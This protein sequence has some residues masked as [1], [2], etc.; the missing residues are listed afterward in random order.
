MK[1]KNELI[2]IVLLLLICFL[3]YASCESNIS[4]TGDSE[5]E[6][7][8]IKRFFE[9]PPTE[10]YSGPLWVWN[11]KITREKI[12]FQLQ[13]FKEENVDQVF[14]HPRPGLITE[15][16]SSE[17]FELC[18]YT[19]DKAKELDMNVWLYD[20]NSFPS[21]FAG[22]H[23]QA[24]MP[25]SYQQGS[26]LNMIKLSQLQQDSLPKE[27]KAIIKQEN[28]QWIDVTDHLTQELGKKG[29]YYVFELIHEPTSGWYGGFAYVDLLYPG[30]TEKF[31]QVTMQGYEE[32]IGD[33]F[34]KRVPGIFTDE[35]NISPRGT[36]EGIKW[37]PHLF[38]EF[39][40]RWGYDLK[41]HLPSLFI[42][43]GDWKKIRHNYYGLLLEL[44]IERWSKPWHEY[45]EANNLK[46]TGH[47]WEH[48][49]PSPHHGGD[50]MAMYAWHQIPA[51]D[52]LF[53]TN[54]LRPDQ[55]GN[56]RA[57]KELSSVV[58]QLG[59]ERALS[60]TYGGAG[61]EL[62]FEDM[63]RLGDW[64]YALGVNFLNQHLAYMTLKGRRKG[65]FPQSISYHAPYWEDYGVL[66]EYY[67]RLSYVLSQGKQLNNTLVIEPTTAAWMYYSPVKPSNRLEEIKNEF[68]D[69]LHLMEKYQLEYD[70]ASEN[71][72]KDHGNVDQNEFVVGLRNYDLVIFPPGLDNLDKTTV[73]L[74]Q[75]YI[76]NGGKI[77]SLVDPPMYVDGQTSD[78]L[79]QLISGKA[80][81]WLQIEQLE[82]ALEILNEP[83][84]QVIDPADIE[85]KVYHQRRKLKDGQIL[86]WTNF[87]KEKHV[88]GAFKIKG[89]AISEMDPFTGQI[90]AYPFQ[91]EDQLLSAQFELA[92]AQS[93]LLFIH[94]D[95]SQNSATTHIQITNI[96]VLDT[97]PSTIKRNQPNTLTLDYLDLKIDGA[98]YNDLYFSMA[99]D[100]VYK[101]HGLAQY[102]RAGYDPWAVAV[103]YRTNILD[104]GKDWGE[105]TGYEATYHFTV[106]ENFTPESLSAVVEW[107]HLYQVSINGKAVNP[108]PEEWWLDQSFA[109]FDIAEHVKP[110]VNHL[111][112][113][114]QPMDIHAEVEPV[115]LRGDFGVVSATSG[116]NLI[117]PTEL[118]LGSW[119]DQN[120]P[121]YSETVSYTKIIA[122]E[123]NQNY[124]VRLNDWNGSVARVKVNGQKAGIIGWQPYELDISGALKQG[125]NAIEVEVVG[126]LKN[127]L[128]PHHNVT[129]RG[130]VTP[131]SWFFAPDSQPQG[132]EYDFL[133]YG[134]FEDFD[135]LAFDKETV[136]I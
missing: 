71:I 118:G 107:A 94:D 79:K 93:L 24:E 48:G 98:E 3:F 127:L 57:I 35:P 113:K 16:L 72:L 6:F 108:V 50:N 11:D 82:E 34:G 132:G 119:S 131:W 114:A 81:S 112:L 23:V 36:R 30:V 12:D 102:G 49:W 96:N 134:L 41:P 20:E 100:S 86:F 25:E 39:Q 26:A 76:Q 123:E 14:I 62:S 8:T 46:W 42:E 128:G 83:D 55:F 106:S 120:M 80:D 129:R 92:P 136:S 40:D 64:E 135:I 2:N 44:F 51:V 45:T 68:Q 91:N 52:M 103:Q 18:R 10:Y 56:V 22:G 21:G 29:D 122:V 99:S 54:E 38:Q 63:K 84:F 59:K 110:G 7:S 105:D 74:L 125:E 17:W 97:Q 121:F 89:G 115:Y 61:W 124:L 43:V 101:L 60:E 78:E 28:E 87:N 27:Y 104:M 126:S 88:S 111:T 109:V 13:E 70:L 95:P 66:A 15:Y 73:D 9:N 116:F 90:K 33:E 53:N 5:V 19:V 67:A 130:I 65:D 133:D 32:Y 75:N 69:F 1:N 37:T 58:N 47:Y 117:A 85:G 31:I 77:I 4:P